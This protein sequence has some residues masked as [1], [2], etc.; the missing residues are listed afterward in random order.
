M[1]SQLLFF[2][3][4]ESVFLRQKFFLRFRE[5]WI[6]DAAVN[7]ADGSALWLFMETDALSA[8]IWNDIVNAFSKRVICFAEK[9][10][11]F[12][13]FVNGGVRTF[14]FASGAIDALLCDH[15]S[16]DGSSKESLRLKM[17]EKEFL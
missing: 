17:V 13:A 10:P 6:G 11:L 3:R 2:V 12:A 14:R 1:Q 8:F 4:F 7:W 5:V 16:H 9:R 15:Q